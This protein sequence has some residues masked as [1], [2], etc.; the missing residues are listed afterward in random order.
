[1]AMKI[2]DGKEVNESMIA[3]RRSLLRLKYFL[4]SRKKAR[5]LSM[6][7]LIRRNIEQP[8]HFD[9]AYLRRTL[10]YNVNFF[11]T[12]FAE[13]ASLVIRIK[14]NHVLYTMF[15]KIS[16]I[17]CTIWCV[18]LLLSETALIFDKSGG[19]LHY[20]SKGFEQ[21]IWVTFFMTTFIISGICISSFFTIFQLKFSDYLQLV[22][23]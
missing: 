10:E 15:Y 7:N 11:G 14:K 13:S 3:E 8:V 17:L 21:N 2:K 20:M 23:K 12:D 22:K 9:D 5:W 16:A 19:I 4:Y 6:Y 1:M 18:F